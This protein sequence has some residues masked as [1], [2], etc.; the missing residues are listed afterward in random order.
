MVL[1]PLAVAE[2]PVGAPGTVFVC[3]GVLTWKTSES[4][5]M[6]RVPEPAAALLLP[7]GPWLLSAE[8]GRP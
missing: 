7:M 4:P 1:V 2:R 3:V 5:Y 8:A 6:G